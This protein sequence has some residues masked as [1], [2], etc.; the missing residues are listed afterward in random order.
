MTGPTEEPLPDYNELTAEE[1]VAKL[2]AVSQRTLGK[3]GAYERA[4]Q[5]RA[6]VL[7]RVESLTAKE[8]APGYDDLTV[9]EIQQLLNGGDEALAKRVR[10]YERTHAA[11]SGVLQATERQ[12]KQA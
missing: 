2:P 6:T 11:R 3:V 8:P 12:L 4:H 7:S 9:A 10:D 1:L 5:A